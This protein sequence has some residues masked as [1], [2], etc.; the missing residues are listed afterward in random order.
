M[1]TRIGRG[2]ACV[3]RMDGRTIHR[4]NARTHPHK[5]P[6]LVTHSGGA[7]G[8]LG[9]EGGTRGGE[10]TVRE[11]GGRAS[12]CLGSV[13]PL[14]RLEV[15][16]HPSKDNPCSETLSF[17]SAPDRKCLVDNHFQETGIGCLNTRSAKCHLM[18]PGMSKAD[19]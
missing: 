8:C 17:L 11:S 16:R 18:T 6:Q 12:R 10:G 4:Y 9:V 19:D 2:A 14:R 13:S 3:G 7:E 1:F 5:H 15:C